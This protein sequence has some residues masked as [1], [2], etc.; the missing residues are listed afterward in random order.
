MGL[1]T[2]N[3]TD[4]VAQGPGVKDDVTMAEAPIQHGGLYSFQLAPP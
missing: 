1:H 4:C 3:I 2:T